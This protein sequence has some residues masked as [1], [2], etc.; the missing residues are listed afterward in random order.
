MRKK[1]SIEE[2]FN[3]DALKTSEIAWKFEQRLEE[4]LENLRNSICKD[5]DE[6]WRECS[7]VVEEVATEVIGN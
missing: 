7:R 6:Y 1:G 2:K 5:V 3:L 4:K